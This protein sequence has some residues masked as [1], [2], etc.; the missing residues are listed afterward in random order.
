[1]SGWWLLLSWLAPALA[2]PLILPAALEAAESA[3]VFALR[4]GVVQTVRAQVG[5]S[6]AAGD[7]L[8]WLEDGDLRLEEEAALLAL[9]QTEKRLARVRVLHE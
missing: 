9:Q 2:E 5:E 4:S 7:T 1:V 6:V 3:L 8:A